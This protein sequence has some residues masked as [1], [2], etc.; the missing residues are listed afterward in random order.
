V[1]EPE[2]AARLRPA[3]V[4][5]AAADAGRA[6]EPVALVT[7][8]EV[9][10]STPRHTGARM[11][12]R[13]DGAIVGSIG[14][15]KIELE[16]IEAARPVARRE[17]PAL[18]F[19]RHLVRD[20]A[21]CCGGR[22]QAW[23]EP[24]DGA[25]WKALDEAT[26]RRKARR[27]CV[28][29]TSMATPGGMDVLSAD[30]SLAAR[31]P[32]LD[33]DRFYDPLLPGERVVLFGGGHVAQALAPLCAAVGFEVVVCDEEP[34]F[35]SAARF[36]DAAMLVQSFDR[37]E[38]TRELGPIGGEDYVIILTRDHAVD[39]QILEQW[40]GDDA[41]GYLGMIG[42][43]GKVGRFR[44]RL[45]AKGVAGPERWQRVHAPVGLNIGAETPEEIAVAI[46][47]E[48]IQ[49]RRRAAGERDAAKVAADNVEA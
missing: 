6:G 32:R 5:A 46:V 33:G 34:E 35:A 36:P 28:L 27:A 16:A 9:A 45:E 1:T 12:V 15:G 13:E 26:R 25:R 39:Q 30:A 37:Q 23:I 14:G 44:R 3:D 48:L 8:V 18:R 20:L 2:Q 19:E 41:V 24:V 38:V 29:V 4:L 49:W 17:A 10:G 11:L 7:V 31:A 22:M 42:S 21:M 40:I 47:A 43:R